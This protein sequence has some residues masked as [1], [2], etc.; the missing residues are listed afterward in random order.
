[1]CLICFDF[2][3]LIWGS[4][5]W[6]D[7]SPYSRSRSPDEPTKQ[8]RS[9]SLLSAN[10]RTSSGSTN[11]NDFVT[12]FFCS[13]PVQCFAYNGCLINFYQM[14]KCFRDQR[15]AIS[16]QKRQL[17]TVMSVFSTCIS[18]K[19]LRLY[20]DRKLLGIP[21]LSSILSNKW[22]FLFFNQKYEP[23]MTSPVVLK[24]HWNISIWEEDTPPASCIEADDQ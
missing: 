5:K 4:Q 11:I 1:M 12:L 6:T 13:T 17:L 24:T 3:W 2:N 14:N 18:L 9:F 21:D 16:G 15:S 8:E 19:V 10:S 20:K 22:G 7:E 23:N